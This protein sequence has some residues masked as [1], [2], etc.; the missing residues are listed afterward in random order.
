MIVLQAKRHRPSGIMSCHV[1]RTG[2]INLEANK[3]NMPSKDL[4][5][6]T[7]KLQAA[8][9]GDGRPLSNIEQPIQGRNDSSSESQLGSL[10]RTKVSL[11][12]SE[13][14]TESNRFIREEWGTAATMHKIY[15]CIRSRPE[16]RVTIDGL[17]EGGPLLAGY[18]R[19][20]AARLF[21]S[22]LK[23]KQHGFIVIHKNS[24]TQAIEHMELGERITRR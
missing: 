20:I 17:L 23:L 4:Q 3:E 15:K 18:K 19:M 8:G 16:G 2:E 9:L 13:R 12:E 5:Q 21:T 1:D 6:L 10:D 22:V 11:G 24:V 7:A 14:T